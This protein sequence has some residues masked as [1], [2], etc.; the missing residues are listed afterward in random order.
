M[1]FY[2]GVLYNIPKTLNK[3]LTLFSL[4]LTSSSRTKQSWKVERSNELSDIS[5]DR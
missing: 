5:V 1:Y 2:V 4:H 3:K